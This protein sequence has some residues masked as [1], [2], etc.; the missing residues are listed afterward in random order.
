MTNLSLINYTNVI[1]SIE[2]TS[3]SKQRTEKKYREKTN[4]KLVFLKSR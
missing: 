2:M 1:K 3:N 4:P